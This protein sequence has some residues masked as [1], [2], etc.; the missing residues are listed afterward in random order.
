MGNNNYKQLHHEVHTVGGQYGSNYYGTGYVGKQSPQIKRGVN[1]AKQ[2]NAF[3]DNPN[4][5][6]IKNLRW[7]G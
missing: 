5:E 2:T 7:I 6:F 1:P 4:D 3:A